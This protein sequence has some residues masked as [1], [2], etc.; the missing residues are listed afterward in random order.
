MIAELRLQERNGI[1]ADEGGDGTQDNGAERPRI[2]SR[3]CDRNQ[4][5]HNART[6]TKGRS[7]M[8]VKTLCDH[9]GKSRSPRGDKSV[10]HPKS[11]RAIAFERRPGLEPGP[12]NPKH[13]GADPCHDQAHMGH[14]APG[15]TAALAKYEAGN[16]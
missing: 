14:A 11:G 1:V 6:E 2:A 8:S 12:A 4:T 5:R 9:P 13:A 10:P 7:L 3:R 16:T 15:V